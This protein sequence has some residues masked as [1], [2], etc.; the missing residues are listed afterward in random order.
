MAPCILVAEAQDSR[1]SSRSQPSQGQPPGY[2]PIRRSVYGSGVR[3]RAT[4][5]GRSGRSKGADHGLTFPI[6]ID[7][8]GEKSEDQENAECE[9]L[10]RTTTQGF[11]QK[12]TL[13]KQRDR[14]LTIER[15]APGGVWV[16]L[17]AIWGSSKL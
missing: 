14:L 10:I 5:R 2:R 15:T 9:T 13:D 8:Y 3:D 11:A 7:R 6:C 1:R 16:S 17:N 4:E 12:S